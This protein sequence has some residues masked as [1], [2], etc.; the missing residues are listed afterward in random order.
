MALVL[1]EEQRLIKQTAKSFLLDKAPVKAL[2]ELRDNRDETGCRRELWREMAELGW[3][4]IVIPEQYGGFDYG[5]VGLGIVLEESGRTLTASPLV[6]SVLLGATAV[7]LG[8][9]E[10]QKETIL[11]AVAAGELLLALALEETPQHAPTR[12]ALA[13]AKS[14]DGFTLS[15]KKLFVLDG[16]VADKLIVVARTS[17]KSGAK[18]GITLFLIDAKSSGITTERVIMVDSRNSAQVTFDNVKVGVDAVLGELDHGYALLERVMDIGRIGLSAEMLGSA[19]EAFERTIAYL[20]ERKQFDVPIGSF[21]ALQHRA[22]KM[23]CEIELSKSLVYKSL[24]AIDDKDEKLP[25]LAAAS[26]AK[27]CETLRLVT[28][29]AVQIFGGMGMTDEQEIG[30]FLKRARVAQQT[31]G[32]QNFHIDRFAFLNGY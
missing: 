20:K 19:Q 1:N 6:S 31:L 10:K 5:Y 23:F 17:G 18:E 22:A 3:V 15:G 11:P 30:F 32:D 24:S 4:G 14:G 16:H 25:V 26:K 29:E 12:I 9:R 13:A 27:V 28:N 7:V 21:Q 2:R 8:G